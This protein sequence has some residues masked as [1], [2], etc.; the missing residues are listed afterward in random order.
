MMKSRRRKNAINNEMGFFP[1]KFD[2]VKQDSCKDEALY[3]EGK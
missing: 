3:Y 2:L 1:D